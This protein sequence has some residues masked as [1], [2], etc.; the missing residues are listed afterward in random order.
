MRIGIVFP[1]TAK[2]PVGG[3]KV[4][5]EY[6]NCLVKKGHEVTIY[7][8]AER[9]LEQY[10]L[11]TP[12]QRICAKLLVKCRPNWFIFDRK[13]RKKAIFKISDNEIE[14]GDVIIATAFLTAQAVSGLNEKKGRKFYFIQDFENWGD[15]TSEEVIESYSLGMTNIVVSKWLEGIVNANTNNKA[16]LITNAI[17]QECFN[18]TTPMENRDKYTIVMHYRTAVG[19]GCSYGLETIKI[20]QKA[21]P[22]LKA[23][24]IGTEEAP[25]DLPDCCTYFYRIPPAQVALINNKASIFMCT[26]VAEGFGLP[27]LEA[28]ACGCA[29]VSTDYEGIHE[30]AID[31][32]NALLSPVRN[33]EAMADNIRRLMDSDEMRISIVKQGI[34]TAQNRTIASAVN[35]LEKI[36]SID[37]ND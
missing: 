33:P 4:L 6:A 32:V 37:S 19:K 14:D 23:Y 16:V 35:K 22:K 28:M 1:G 10:N 7:Y 12:V 24:I 15:V 17:D 18:V 30:Y 9:L 13:V 21:Y 34:E 26:S 11:I 36:L 3:H 2:A 5:Y 29:V 8:L 31:G 27:G 25:E 20:L